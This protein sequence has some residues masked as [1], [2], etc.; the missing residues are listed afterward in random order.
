[1]V[2]LPDPRLDRRLNFGC[3]ALLGFVLG[4]FGTLSLGYELVGSVVIAT[5]VAI[6]TGV[7]TVIFG[8]RL[9]TA[10]FEWFA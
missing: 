6:A 2:Q 8:D 5:G 9:L 3:G 7:L 10:I 1:M 4:F